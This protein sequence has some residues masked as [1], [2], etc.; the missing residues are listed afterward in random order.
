MENRRRRSQALA[1]LLVVI[2]TVLFAGI[3]VALI[4]V[5]NLSA[6]AKTALVQWGTAILTGTILSAA[7]YEWSSSRGRP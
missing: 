4:Y 7:A 5:E 3:C 1:I 6:E 2:G